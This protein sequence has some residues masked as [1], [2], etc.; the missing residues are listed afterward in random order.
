MKLKACESENVKLKEEISE[1]RNDAINISN[2]RQVICA[3]LLTCE[4][5]R[6]EL[7]QIYATY[8]E[9]IKTLEMSQGALKELIIKKEEELKCAM[10]TIDLWNKGS[11]TLDN[12][13]GS[14]QICSDKSGTGFGGKKE[15]KQSASTS[16]DIRTQGQGEHKIQRKEKLLNLPRVGKA[17]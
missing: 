10:A 3:K 11:K 7:Q 4:T 13:I 16:H 15:Q 5:E 6:N 17:K 8:E 14:Q 2:D 12:I 1:A 9:K